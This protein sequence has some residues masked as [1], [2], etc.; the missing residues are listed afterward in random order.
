MNMVENFYWKSAFS[1]P[2]TP[3][4]KFHGAYGWAICAGGERN[5]I[6]D[7]GGQVGEDLGKPE[8]DGTRTVCE[9]S[10][11]KIQPSILIDTKKKVYINFGSQMNKSFY[12][13][14]LSIE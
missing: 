7:V 2:A 14:F 8:W 13:K 12:Y 9:F 1:A 11:G 6:N 5:I 3:N 4:V 10:D